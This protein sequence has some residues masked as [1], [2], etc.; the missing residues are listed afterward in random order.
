MARARGRR[1]RGDRSGDAPSRRGGGLDAEIA[2]PDVYEPLRARWPALRA[3]AS[4]AAARI[5][6]VS[7]RTAAMLRRRWSSTRCSSASRRS[8]ARPR[9][10]SARIC[11]ARHRAARALGRRRRADGRGRGRAPRCARIIRFSTRCSRLSLEP[12]P[13]EIVVVTH[14]G[15][16]SRVAGTFSPPVGEAVNGSAEGRSGA[17]HRRRCR[18]SCTPRAPDQSGAGRASGGRDLHAASAR[19]SP[20]REVSTYGSPAAGR[21]PRTAAA[22]RSGNDRSAPQPRVREINLTDSIARA[23]Q[24]DRRSGGLFGS[25]GF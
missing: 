22:A 24:T 18:S 12:S 10:S 15:E 3:E 25:F 4:A 6:I 5:S 9:I 16:C 19:G 17:V 11:P 21:A 7:D 14:Q 1:H 13:G 2:P 23:Q 20:V 8:P